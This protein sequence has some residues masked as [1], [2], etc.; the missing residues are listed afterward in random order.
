MSKTAGVPRLVAGFGLKGSLTAPIERKRISV[1]SKGK[2]GRKIKPDFTCQASPNYSFLSQFL[3]VAAAGNGTKESLV[4]LSCRSIARR[5]CTRNGW[6][7][8]VQCEELGAMVF[9]MT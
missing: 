4:A 8:T 6:R 7:V 5:G 1:P 9:V 3:S 2:F